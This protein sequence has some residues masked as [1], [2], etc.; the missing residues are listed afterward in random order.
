MT[1]IR[2]VSIPAAIVILTG[3]AAFAQAPASS[4][5]E[6]ASAGTST[7]L[8]IMFGSDFDR[9]GLVTRA[10][11]NIGIGHTFGFLNSYRLK[12]GRIGCD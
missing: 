2:R 5:T 8:F 1:S 3:G 4:G 11:Y 10:N 12:A 9:P 7:D 6:P